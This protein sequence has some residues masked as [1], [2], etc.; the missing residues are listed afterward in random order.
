MKTARLEMK[1]YRA[2]MRLRRAG[3]YVGKCET[4]TQQQWERWIDAHFGIICALED[5]DRPPRLSGGGGARRRS[6]R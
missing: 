3:A 2:A 1:L 6:K 4:M 5:Y